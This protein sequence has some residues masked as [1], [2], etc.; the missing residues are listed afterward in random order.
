MKFFII[1][2]ALLLGG[3]GFRPIESVSIS[4]EFTETNREILRTAALEWAAF[5]GREVI[6]SDCVSDECTVRP[7]E[8]CEGI[9]VGYTNLSLT[10]AATID[11]CESKIDEIGSERLLRQTMLH[12]LGHALAGDP[13]HLPA[14][15]I[16]SKSS[17]VASDAITD[18]DVEF[19]TASD[20]Q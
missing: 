16:M 4:S 10:K 20:S 14:G 11:I 19:V 5:S 6:V 9:T 1:A 18:L 12:E 13:S 15:N 8:G 3:C 2:G 7:I 17:K